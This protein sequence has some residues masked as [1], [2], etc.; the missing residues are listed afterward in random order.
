MNS[1]NREEDS[2]SKDK[3]VVLLSLA[4]IILAVA[5]LGFL[6]AAASIVFLQDQ[7][8]G[9]VLIDLADSLAQSQTTDTPQRSAALTAAEL[10]I[11]AFGLFGSLALSAFLAAIYRSQNRVLSEQAEIQDT[12]AKIMEG[13]HIPL[14]AAG[15]AGVRLHDGRPTAEM[16]DNGELDVSVTTE[17]EQWVSVGLQN[18]SEEIAQQIQ[19]VCLLNYSGFELDEPLTHGVVPLEVDGMETQPEVGEGALLSK[20]A[21]LSLLRARPRFTKFINGTETFQSF[22]PALRTLLVDED[23]SEDRTEGTVQFGFVVIFTNPVDRRFK[24]LL[25]RAYALSSDDFTNRNDVTVGSI[26]RNAIRQDIEDLVEETD[27]EIPE[28]AFKSRT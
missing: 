18:H 6:G 10:C 21:G 25:D 8:V 17:N 3:Y 23:P 11:N 22:L 27:W 16:T 2:E 12:Q 1:F 14:L 7:V 19:L 4:G 5:A 28:A 26:K 15:P 20:T 24:L 13:S 9:R